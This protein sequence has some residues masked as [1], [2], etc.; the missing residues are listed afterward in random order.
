MLPAAR[1]ERLLRQADVS[2]P[3]IEAS[4]E[5]YQLLLAPVFLSR[6]LFPLI[7]A[8]METLVFPP[9]FRV[10]MS[11]P[12]GLRRGRIGVSRQQLEEFVISLQLLGCWY[13]ERST[14]GNAEAIGR[15]AG[16]QTAKSPRAFPTGLPG[17][18]WNR[19]TQKGSIPGT[20]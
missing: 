15:N 5:R 13:L 7:V 20:A 6:S 1:Q 4:G 14:P 9:S 10:I 18:A 17:L 3:S 16:K 12:I 8:I 19:R 11:C 2:A